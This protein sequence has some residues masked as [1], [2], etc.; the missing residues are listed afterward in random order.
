MFFKM[1]SRML[2]KAKKTSEYLL[3]CDLMM[4]YGDLNAF[5]WEKA[6]SVLVGAEETKIRKMCC[7][8]EFSR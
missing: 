6:G 7:L 2:Q 8:D 1:S 5:L 4:V 3:L